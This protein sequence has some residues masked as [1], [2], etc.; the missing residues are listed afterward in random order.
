MEYALA[1]FPSIHMVN[2]IKKRLNRDG[3]YFGMIRAPH[4]ISPGGCGFAIRFE[5][6][7]LPLLQQTAQELD[8]SITGIYKEIFQN[9]S[10]GYTR[11]G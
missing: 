5:E 11:I 9:G 3:H 1:V 8:V 10:K 6:N 2:Q 4:S 7:K